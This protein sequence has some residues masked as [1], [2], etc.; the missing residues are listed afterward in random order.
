L[1]SIVEPPR[2]R[3]WPHRGVERGVR[4]RGSARRGAPPAPG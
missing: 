4:L 1:M 2:M 3:V